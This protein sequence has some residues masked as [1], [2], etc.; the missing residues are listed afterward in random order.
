MP[1]SLVPYQGPTLGTNGTCLAQGIFVNVGG[2]AIMDATLFLAGYYVCTALRM[3]NWA[4]TRIYEPAC[5]AYIIIFNFFGTYRLVKSGF[6][7]IRHWSAFCGMSPIPNYC[8]DLDA[9]TG[10]AGDVDLSRCSW[11][12][13]PHD[14]WF[15]TE[16]W[17]RYY[18]LVASI[19]LVLALIVVIIVVCRNEKKMI[20]EE[21]MMQ[22]DSSESEEELGAGD[23]KT[24]PKLNATRLIIRQAI[25]YILAFFLTWIFVIIPWDASSPKII[26]VLESILLPLGGFW[27]MLI[28]V[29][30]K[31]LLVREANPVIDSNLKAF[32]VLIREPDTVPEMVLSGMENVRVVDRTFELEQGPN[33]DEEGVSEPSR[34]TSHP[35]AYDGL[36]M[37]TPSDVSHGLS[38]I[39]MFSSVTDSTP[40]PV[41]NT[42]TTQSEGGDKASRSSGEASKSSGQAPSSSNPSDASTKT[43]TIV[44]KEKKV[45]RYYAEIAAKFNERVG[46]NQHTEDEDSKAASERSPTSV[47]DDVSSTGLSMGGPSYGG[48]SNEMPAIME[49]DDRE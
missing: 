22:D 34:F 1:K 37:E 35:S 40:T 48:L 13:D 15:F 42:N 39:S 6:I 49:D 27:N 32:M 44:N 33:D 9:W 43:G 20:K 31:I 19:L 41:R 36:S 45:Y 8:H 38:K 5:F 26:E 18:T 21:S 25:M 16:N 30:I 12:T 10:M 29:H 17:L 14:A 24:P 28:F 7:N 4:I 46:L 3:S 11:P 47:L 23:T 2:G